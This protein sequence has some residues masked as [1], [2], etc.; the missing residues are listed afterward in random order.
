MK[1]R[2]LTSLKFTLK[3]WGI[4]YNWLTLNIAI[5]FSFHGFIFIFMVITFVTIYKKN[6]FFTVHMETIKI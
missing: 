2:S 5:L 1:A 4:E 3:N 6:Q